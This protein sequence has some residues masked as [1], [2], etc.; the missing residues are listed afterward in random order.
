MT[1][2]GKLR[3]QELSDEPYKTANEAYHV[4]KKQYPRNFRFE[5][6]KKCRKLNFCTELGK[7]IL[8]SGKM[9][10]ESPTLSF[11]LTDQLFE[12]LFYKNLHI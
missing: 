9:S 2:W 5:F 8:M 10:P 3:R 12:P 11:F 4:A 1:C 6:K 7:N